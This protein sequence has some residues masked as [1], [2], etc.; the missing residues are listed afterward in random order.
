MFVEWFPMSG[1]FRVFSCEWRCLSSGFLWVDVCWVFSCEWRCL[2]SAFL[3]MKMP[4]DCFP[5]S[6]DA[7]WVLSCEWR[8]LSTVFLWVD[9]SFQRAFRRVKNVSV[10]NSLDA[11]TRSCVLE[12]NKACRQAKPISQA[13]RGDLLRN[14]SSYKCRVSARCPKPKTQRNKHSPAWWASMEQKVIRSLSWSGPALS[15]WA[16]SAFQLFSLRIFF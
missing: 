7:C 12:E 4:V 6:G 3:W 1:F 16:P 14:R 13:Y 5:A 2:L 15:L 10:T 8:C 11:A 9:L